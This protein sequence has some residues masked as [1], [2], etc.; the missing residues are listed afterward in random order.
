MNI[1]LEDAVS[2]VEL[3]SVPGRSRLWYI[4]GYR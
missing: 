2:V 4:R 3:Y 1:L